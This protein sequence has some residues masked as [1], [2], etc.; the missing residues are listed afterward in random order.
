[1]DIPM[2]SQKFPKGS[3][4]SMRTLV[5]TKETRLISHASL[6]SS[7]G[8]LPLDIRRQFDRT[9]EKIPQKKTTVPTM[10][11]FDSNLTITSCE[12]ALPH[13]MPSIGYF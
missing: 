11:T 3:G 8:E 5:R 12:V 1:M 2:I 13:P 10:P 6:E 7:R 4:N 9:I